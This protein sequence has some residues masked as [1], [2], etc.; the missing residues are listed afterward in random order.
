MIPVLQEIPLQARQKKE[1]G[2]VGQ[3]A[4]LPFLN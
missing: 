1:E 2:C 3:E 4:S